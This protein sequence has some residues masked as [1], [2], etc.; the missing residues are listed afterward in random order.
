MNARQAKKKLH[1]LA[2][3]Q[4][5]KILSRFFKTGPGQYGEG[6]KFLGVKVPNTRAL[7]RE[8]RDLEWPEIQK[9]VRTV[10]HEERMLG[11]LILVSRYE[12][13]N[14][15]S[16]RAQWTRRYLSLRQYI[17]NWD[18]VDVTAPNVLG[19]SLLENPRSVPIWALV[20]S[21]RRW[22]RRLA[23]LASFQPLRNGDFDLTL[24]LCRFLL[25]DPEDLMHKAC[26]WMLREIGK[27]DLRVLRE[28]LDRHARLMPR[29]MLRAS[30]EKLGKKERLSYL[31]RRT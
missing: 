28:F 27:R 14:T 9:L 12:R 15:S 1:K 2:N 22:D 21:S 18:L 16:E 30:I 8:F 23:V 20:R 17:N 29:T 19:R 6:D 4:Q 24:R 13:S 5:A 26:G 10:F 11:L 25:K 7:V 3:T 31:A